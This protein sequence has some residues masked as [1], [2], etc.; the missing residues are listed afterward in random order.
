MDHY[1]LKLLIVDDK[2][3]EREGIR[4]IFNWGS[5]GIHIV[6]EAENGRE[7]IEKARQLLPDIIITD[8]VMPQF[9]GFKMIEEIRTFLPDIKV[10]FMSCFDNFNFVKSAI[11]LDAM[12]YVL[13]PV[14]S[15]ELLATVSKVTGIHIRELERRKEEED[16][17]RRLR[18]SLPILREQFYKDILIGKFESSHEVWDK[19][20]F[21]DARLM[22]GQFIVM[23]TELD[24]SGGKLGESSEISK[25]L[26][27]MQVAECIEKICMELGLG[28]SFCITAM[29]KARFAII[30]NHSEESAKDF[31][32]EALADKLK[33]GIYSQFG[34]ELAI[35]VSSSTTDILQIGRRYQEACDALKFKSYLGANQTINYTD[36]YS[37]SSPNE[38]NT[39]N[40]VAVQNELKYLL[41]TG[42]RSDI[43]KFV[44]ELFHHDRDEMNRQYIQFVCISVISYIQMHLI[45]L[46]ESLSSIFDNEFIVFEK[47]SQMHTI[48][49]LQ[50]WLKSLIESV[51][52]HLNSKHHKKNKKV[53]DTILAFMEGHYFEELSVPSI[54]SKVY[55]SPCYTNYIFRK[56]TGETL[57]EH[58]AGIRIEE[59][60]KLL[61]GSLL[62]VYEI[63]E[64]VGYKNNSYFSTVFKERCGMTPLEY[65]DRGVV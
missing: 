65:R 10:I 43:S 18:E 56:E 7:G 51:S 23:M 33:S 53:I 4:D 25:Q 6:G 41:K 61:R 29:D 13:K 28:S 21:L 40:A 19:N 57:M 12:G 64:K 42:E 44:D 11:D 63:S 50:Q 16:L 38:L 60:K 59:A 31:T 17:L 36:I 62:K 1:A 45:E 58:L 15:G 8:I 5:I 30:L 52:L 27:H 55:L 24:S 47:I 37:D 39:F 14:I 2:P 32:T 35:G 22:P 54:A 48:P 34:L 3:A 9:D 49:E 26:L 46:N 20:K